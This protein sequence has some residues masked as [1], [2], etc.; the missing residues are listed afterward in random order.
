MERVKFIPHAGK[1][2]LVID[3]S[4]CNPEEALLVISQ[5][6]AVICKSAP[7]SLLTLANVTNIGFDNFLNER[8]KEFVAHNKPFVKAAAVV[9]VAGLKKILFDATMVF[10]KRKLHAFDTMEQA[11]AWLISN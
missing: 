5:A 6:K 3:F 1:E 11:K 8:M 7:A 10:S 2:I 9:G 4:G